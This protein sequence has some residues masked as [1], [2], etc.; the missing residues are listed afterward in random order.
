MSAISNL[1]HW[2][3]FQLLSILTPDTRASS[4][5]SSWHILVLS[6]CLWASPVSVH[7]WALFLLPCPCWQGSLVPASRQSHPVSAAG[8]S[9]HVT[10]AG[11]HLSL[12][13]PRS[14]TYSRGTRMAPLLPQTCGVSSS[15]SYSCSWRGFTSYSLNS[16]S[17]QFSVQKSML[18]HFYIAMAPTLHFSSSPF[19]C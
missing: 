4:P 13:L 12:A 10:S 16:I 11:P 7:L 2:R 9:V 19:S 6:Q 1:L 17:H 8:T 15:M 18:F 14:P 5:C 3:I